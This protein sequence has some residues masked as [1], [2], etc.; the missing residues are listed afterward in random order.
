MAMAFVSTTI[1]N[2]K[3]QDNLTGL[4]IKKEISNV[5]EFLAIQL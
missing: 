4:A 3:R 1:A 5:K 2:N